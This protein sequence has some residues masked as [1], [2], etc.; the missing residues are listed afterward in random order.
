MIK[1][2]L[3][4]LGRL[5]YILEFPKLGWLNIILDLLYTGR[6]SHLFKRFGR[7]ST[8]KRYVD[9]IV[10]PS[11]ISVGS[12]TKI[13]KRAVITSWM[14][15]STKVFGNISIGD[16]CQIGDDVHI[17]ATNNVV[18]G[19]DVLMGKKITISDN[20]HGKTTIDSMSISPLIR[21]CVSK[22]AVIIEDNV[23]I[24]DKATILSN[25]TIGHNSIVAA[26]AVVTHDVPP[27]CVVGGIPAKIIKQIK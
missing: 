22:G 21:P 16:R 4:K 24:G 23:W 9:S 18:I 11:A 8:L 5:F 7:G 6:Y 3:V 17:T 19:N 10:N 26:N 12:C 2:I 25:V 13:G 1:D 15:P 27:F 20:S 14:C